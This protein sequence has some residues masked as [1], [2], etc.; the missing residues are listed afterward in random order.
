VKKTITKLSF[1]SAALLLT[2]SLMAVEN[3]LLKGMVASNQVGQES[4]IEAKIGNL[5]II[6]TAGLKV[7][8]VDNI[9]GL[10]SVKVKT[11]KGGAT[12]I[13]VTTDLKLL[14]HS[15]QA[16][17]TVTGM[18]YK[19]PMDMTSFKGKENISYG[20]GPKEIYVFTD[21]ECPY[22]KQFE[23]KWDEAFFKKYTVKVFLF[24]LAMH[25]DA[26]AMS[27]WVMGAK[28]EKEKIERLKAT[29]YSKEYKS[30]ME[31]MNVPEY[32]KAEKK[33]KEIKDLS[34]AA[35]ITGTPTVVDSTG[36]SLLWTTL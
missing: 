10:Y 21:P 19:A 33:L 28:T 29:K 26:E 31:T 3:P 4:S 7:L 2:T 17:D 13:Y 5:G 16:I 32:K 15:G 25:K 12:N 18:P 14:I 20:V 6:K 11:E 30:Y 23:D 22:C 34:T 8:Q 35:G 9:S 24:P 27:F 1:V 36:K